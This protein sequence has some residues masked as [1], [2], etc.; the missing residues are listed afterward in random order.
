[1]GLADKHNALLLL[2]VFALLLGV[3]LFSLTFLKSDQGNVV[4]VGEL[5]IE[6]TNWR[7]M[8]STKSVEATL[9]PR[10]IRMNFTVPSMAC[11]SGT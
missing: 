8:G 7:L 4:V 9:C 5:L 2:E 6:V 1:L 11:S 3:V 10:W